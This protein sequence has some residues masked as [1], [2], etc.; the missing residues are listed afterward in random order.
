MAE[1]TDKEREWCRLV[2]QGVSKAEAYRKAY[3]RNEMSAAAAN[4]AAYRLSQKGDVLSF[5]DS[6]RTAADVAAVLSREDRMMMLSRMAVGSEE[7]GDVNGAVSCIREL[8]KMDGAY[9]QPDGVQ[10]NVQQG[11]SIGDVVASVMGVNVGS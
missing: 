2:A 10:V 8:N 11:L 7:N 3:N 5:L 9:A 6:L 1:L 4:K